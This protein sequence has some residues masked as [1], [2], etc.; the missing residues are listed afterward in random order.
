MEWFTDENPA[1][2][3]AGNPII[4]EAKLSKWLRSLVVTPTMGAEHRMTEYLTAQIRASPS[5]PR[6]KETMKAA[7]ASLKLVVPGRAFERAFTRAVID[8]GAPAW[9]KG[10]NTRR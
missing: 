5:A 10:G 1:K 7:A 2:S 6:S 4:L 3:I 9:S 8:A